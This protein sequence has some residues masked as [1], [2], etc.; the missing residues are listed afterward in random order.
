MIKKFIY[1]FV[2]ILPLFSIGQEY[3][4]GLTGNPVIKS[5]LKENPNV[6]NTKNDILVYESLSLP[7]F[8]DFS[9]MTIYPDTSRWLNDEAYINANFP[10]F[11]PDFGV[12]TLDAIDAYGN[13]YPEASVVPFLADRLVSKPIRLDSSFI[14]DEGVIRALNPTDSVYFSFF[15]QPQGRGDVPLSYD[16][17]L[18]QFGSYNG[19][20]IFSH[21]NYIEVFGINYDLI[22]TNGYAPPGAVIYPPG[23]CDTN[24]AYLL[25]DTF[26]L[27]ESIF[28]PC[29]SVFV[30]D[31]DWTTVWG[32][33]G[34]TLDD[35]INENG[36]FFKYEV[37]PIVDTT[38]F[39]KDF[40]FR[41]I[42]YASISSIASWQSN[43]DHWHI[44]RVKLDV[45]RTMKDKFERK[46]QFVQE[47]KTFIK[48]YTS[49]PHNQYASNP[50]IFK[51]DSTAAYIHNLD[52]LSHDVVYNYYVQ[53][54]NGDT[55]LGFLINDY[56]NSLMPL[57]D[58]DIND[59]QPFVRR[60]IK[61]V[62]V[63][64]SQNKNFNFKISHVARDADSLQLGDTL[65]YNQLFSNYM[66]L[67]DG[68]VESGYGL[69]PA[70]SKLAVKYSTSLVD[71]L[72]G[73]QM[74]FNKTHSNANYKFFHITV[75]QDNNGVPGNILYQYQNIK[76][77]FTDGLN[78]FHTYW[79]PD[80]VKLGVEDFYVG[81]EQT[82]GDLLN[83]G[84]DKNINTKSRNF[85]N[86]GSA[87]VNSSIE[88]SI[89]IRPVLDKDPYVGFEENIKPE[90]H[91]KVYPNP[92]KGGNPISI[93]LNEEYLQQLNLR[94]LEISIFDIYGKA[95][96]QGQYVEKIS[97]I[98]FQNGFYILRIIDHANA[99]YFTSKL[100]IN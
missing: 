34:D 69:S 33:E 3:L 35:F 89:M 80:P 76:P 67:D 82:T 32:A 59:Y 9:K 96:Y 2:F 19:N 50:T 25:A 49:M 55:L 5:Y 42:N 14:A 62:F 37:I 61:Y 6:L 24:L 53:K 63:T 71:T 4:M 15:Y 48:P 39:R 16:S 22:V 12:A 57:H 87:W 13:V 51:R 79:F 40:Q 20:L 85:F 17:L 26:F 21:F 65:I 44:D 98:G 7:F 93:K 23:G 45:K 86:L 31:S 1:I 84:L 88:G 81:W 92:V 43:T 18:L 91:V 41:F 75:W 94:D 100:L 30:V 78:E 8:D 56:T 97:T 68:S 70:G 27:D 52:S 29:D 38:W 90:I 83:I 95:V 73:V 74:F 54:E 28:I 47:A 77:N 11:P 46:V 66:S 10:Y 36:S 72:W 58:V 60:P 99:K 64:G